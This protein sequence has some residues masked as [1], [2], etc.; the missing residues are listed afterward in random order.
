[1]TKT[2]V[3]QLTQDDI[4]AIS[5]VARLLRQI[6]TERLSS[7]FVVDVIN[8]DGLSDLEGVLQDYRRLER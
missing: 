2:L 5:H 7:G 1:M 4:E 8:D 6:N 3:L